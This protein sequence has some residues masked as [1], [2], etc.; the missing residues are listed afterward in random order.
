MRGRKWFNRVATLVA[1]AVVLS[2]VVLG[3]RKVWCFRK[4][5]GETIGG[6]AAETFGEYEEAVATK[7]S[8]CTSVV[9]VGL[10]GEVVDDPDPSTPIESVTGQL[11]SEPITVRQRQE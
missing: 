9:L 3:S 11:L 6:F 10:D 4:V 8:G 7:I 2:L 1:A 5:D